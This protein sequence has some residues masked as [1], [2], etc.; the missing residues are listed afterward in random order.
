E[1]AGIGGGGRVHDPVSLAF[2]ALRAARGAASRAPG[3]AVAIVGGPRV[4]AALAG[5]AAAARA[6]VE[7]RLGQTL[8]LRARPCREGFEIV[9]E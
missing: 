1:A 6:V 5:P 3:R 9:L 8:A 2:A 7:E 4:M